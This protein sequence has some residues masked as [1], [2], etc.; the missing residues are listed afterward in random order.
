MANELNK[1]F[2]R[3]MGLFMMN[4]HEKTIININHQMVRTKIA[5]FNF[6]L[7]GIF[8]INI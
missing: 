3:K 8:K 6:I 7:N 4:V 2:S 5:Q 1:S